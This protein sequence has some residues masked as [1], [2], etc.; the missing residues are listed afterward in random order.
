ML[1]AVLAAGA[2]LPTAAAAAAPPTPIPLDSG[3]QIRDAVAAPAQPQPAPPDESEE[4]NETPNPNTVP[5]RTVES[6]T[7]WRPV[8]VPSVFATDAAP[9]LFG[10]TVKVYRLRFTAPRARGFRWAFGSSRR[11]GDRP[12]C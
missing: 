12:S 3:W 9:E 2:C 1:V 10:G 5:D 11:G 4:G 7:D 6:N 8:R